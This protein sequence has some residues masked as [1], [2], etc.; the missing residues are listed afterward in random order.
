MPSYIRSIQGYPRD[1]GTIGNIEYNEPTGAIKITDFGK[2]LLPFL[3]SGTYTTNLSA[4]A[5]QL[6]FIGAVLAVYNNS[7]TLGSVTFGT[8]NTVTSLAPGVTDA[9]GRV[10]FPC[11]PN[12][13]TYISTATQ[14]WAISS[15]STLLVFLVD[16]PSVIRDSKSIEYLT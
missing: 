9:S 2:H 13:W 14:N 8:D 5:V 6:P 1:L 16:D 10:G 12:G 4:A 11:I 15:A 7:D 3:Q